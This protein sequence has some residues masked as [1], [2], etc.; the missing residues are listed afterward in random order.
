MSGRITYFF[1]DLD[2][3]LALALAL[4]LTANVSLANLAAALTLD[5]SFLFLIVSDV[6]LPVTG[7]L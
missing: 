4:D 2:L 3:G 7:W 1:L 5:K 6:G